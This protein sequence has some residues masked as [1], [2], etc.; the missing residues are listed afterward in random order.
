MQHLAPSSLSGFTPIPEGDYRL[1]RRALRFITEEAQAQPGLDEMAEA[2]GV[3]AAELTALFRRWAGLTPKAFL[4]AVT[5]NHAKALL[6]QGLPLL[7]TAIELGL[8]G[9]SRLHDLF[10]THE[11]ISP[12]DYKTGGAGLDIAYDI[13]PSP[14]GLALPMITERGLCGLAFA[15]EGGEA[16]AFEDMRRRWPRAR[17]RRDAA[18]ARTHAARIFEPALW[19]P[20]RPLKLFLIGTDFELRVWESLL[21]IPFA[22]ATT[23]ASIAARIEKPK[24]ARA[25]GAAVGRNPLSFVVPC[26]RV[27]GKSGN[28]TGY[29]WGLT[30]KRAMLGWEAGHST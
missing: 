29:H 28:L 3:S 18:L 1:V 8:S 24:A 30:R 7:D 25:V 22:R 11:A 14:F 12:G 17:Y 2:T 15:D 9:P 6:D 19:Q 13:V 23:Y 5:L 27:L 20:E 16:A 26:H 4:Q 21:A 10:I